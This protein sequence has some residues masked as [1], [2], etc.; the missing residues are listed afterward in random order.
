MK[1]IKNISRRDTE[2]TEKKNLVNFALCEITSSIVDPISP[3]LP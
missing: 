3:D 2:L 1:Y